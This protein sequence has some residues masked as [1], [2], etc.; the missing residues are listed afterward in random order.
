MNTNQEIKAAE[1]KIERSLSSATTSDIITS[2][3][4]SR[5]FQI[6][7]PV[8]VQ[9]ALKN[10]V[11]KGVLL[12]RSQAVSSYSINPCNTEPHTQLGLNYE[13]PGS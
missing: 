4:V 8:I 13:Q 6:T 10:L 1:S 5:Q 11:S 7:N 12:Q 3:H 2:C 9:E